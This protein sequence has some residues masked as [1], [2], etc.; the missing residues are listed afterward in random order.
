MWSLAR[1][2]YR[3]VVSLD[4]EARKVTEFVA[5]ACSGHPKEC[6]VLD[7]GCGNGRYLR[8]LGESGFDITGLDANPELVQANRK[9]GL[10]CLTIEEF[11]Q[12]QDTYDVV[13]MS[14]VIEHFSPKDLI[15][16]LDGYLDRLKVGGRVIIA[17]PL[18]TCLF[19]DDFDHVKPYH[20]RGLL[21]VFGDGQAQVQY[22][23]R[24]KLRLE[25]VW[26]RRG[27]RRFA[28]RRARYVRSPATRLLQLLELGGALAFRLS[29]GIIG[30]ADGWVG[31]FRKVA[32]ASSPSPKER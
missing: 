11:V 2:L 12:T 31:M 30:Q 24:N 29:A 6:R 14:H 32:T 17:T 4:Q 21:M 23:S 9:A 18:L 28:H 10:H 3:A 22:Y 13:L 27:P 8:K 7:V 5:N 25:D 1:S 20:P 15:P 16:F 26:I 19:F